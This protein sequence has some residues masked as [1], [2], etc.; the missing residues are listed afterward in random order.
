MSFVKQYST[1]VSNQYGENIKII[2]S[3]CKHSEKYRYELYNISNM[4]YFEKKCSK[5]YNIQQPI[6]VS[7]TDSDKCPTNYIKVY[8]CSNQILFTAKLEYDNINEYIQQLK[9]YQETKLIWKELQNAKRILF[10]FERMK[11]AEKILFDFNTNENTDND[12]II[13]IYTENFWQ[14]L[15]ENKLI[16]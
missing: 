7:E 6:Y 11:N 3:Y 5:N 4:R 16:A 14:N 9:R 13:P 8:L 1:M 10:E 15:F 2:K 12:T